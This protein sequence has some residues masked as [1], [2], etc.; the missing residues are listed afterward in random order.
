[1]KTSTL[2][3]KIT[4]VICCIGL[5]CAAFLVVVGSMVFNRTPESVRAIGAF[6]FEI[7]LKIADSG[8]KQS[9]LAEMAS[10]V[11]E[12]IRTLPDIKMAEAT[13]STESWV[14][15]QIVV[16]DPDPGY[17]EVGEVLERCIPNAYVEKPGVFCTVAT[18]QGI[19]LS[20]AG[21]PIPVSERSSPD[22]VR[23]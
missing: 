18:E 16:T 12:G 23:E 4:A 17:E 9:A 2:I 5:L 14:K 19:E 11:T 13:D 8:H 3:L 10:E 7:G 22:V 20:D 21:Q 1:M 15:I 6:T